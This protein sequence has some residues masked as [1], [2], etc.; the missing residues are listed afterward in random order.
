M[1]DYALIVGGS[2][3]LGL[4]S[5]RK[6]A[7]EGFNI[8]IVHRD[9]RSVLE[10]FEKDIEKL[11]SEGAD[12]HTFNVDGTSKEKV[13]TTCENLLEV[14]GEAKIKILLHSLS[15]GNLKSL[16]S[17]SEPELTEEDISLTINAM[18]INALTWTKAL[19]KNNLLTENGRIITLTSAGS[20][21]YWSGYAAV[22]MAKSALEILTK[23]L[24]I[25][26]AER[27]IRVNAINAGITDT[28]SLKFIPG[29]D[30]LV[31]EATARNPL[32]RMTQPEDIA[33]VVYL[34]TRSEANW[35][36]GSILN[37]DGGESLI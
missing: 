34:L 15:R 37:V 14:V 35:I 3:G 36:N 26:L 1:K 6:L 17:D 29:Y 10:A 5:A 2:S 33:D 27:N 25:E 21:K 22:A 16:V 19:V 12:V 24:A 32:G 18:A 8:L 20:T 7:K 30:K 9:R 11:K 28:P 13:Q 31:E 23:Y 4:A